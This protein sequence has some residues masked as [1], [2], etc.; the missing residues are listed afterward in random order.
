MIEIVGLGDRLTHRPSE[1]SGGQQQR[2]AVARALASRP[3]VVFADEPTGNLDSKSGQDVLALLRR[4]VDEFGQTVVMVTHDPGAA[5]V[6]DRLLLLGDG[7]VE[8]DGEAGLD[9][10]RHRPDEEP[11]RMRKVTLR[12]LFARRM[13]LALTLLA[14]A[15]GVSLIV[16]TYVFT[17]TING[18]FDNI[19][20][21]SYK[22]TDV[23]ITPKEEIEV[24]D[25]TTLLTIPRSVLQT[26]RANPDVEV[27][28]GAVFDV[29][30]VLGKDG[31]RI[32]AGGAP[33]FIARSPA[34]PRFDGVD[35]GRGPLPADRRRGGRSTVAAKKKEDF[36]LGDP[37]T[38]QG[39]APRK[40]YTHRRL[41]EARRR[42]LVRRRDRRRPDPAPRRCGCSA[43]TATTRSRSPPSRA[44]RP[45]GSSPRCAASCRPPSTCAPARSRATPTRTTSREDL[46]FLQTF[47][48]VFGFVSLFVGAFIIFNSFSI[49]V[50]Q[51]T[52]EIGLLRA[53]GATRRQVL[54]SVLTEGLLLGVVGSLAG[55]ALGIALA[56]L[57]QGAVRRDRAS[58]CPRTALVIE[59]RTIVVPLVVGT[60]V[61]VAVEPGPGGARDARRA[62]GRA[63]RGRRA[64]DG[65]RLAPAD[66]DRARAA[67]SPASG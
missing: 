52:R 20:E 48:L 36:E 24:E 16:A 14:V 11:R 45:S 17:D 8:H 57:L 55:L 1:L 5:S 40:D 13:R 61:A 53:L 7:R 32:G 44:S 63:A 29:G 22:G 34:T 49:T 62:D 41:H 18:S 35:R 65:A 51:R 43:R 28:E 67:A 4:S 54:R 50:A 39:A 47:L 19:F 27:A 56:P 23:A 15:L 60:L 37:L 25:G 3:A 33:N 59:T 26:V 12:G 38:V 31:E 6:A 9:G 58:T 10:R 42:R 66:G 30:T 2:V 64:D 21:E 46:G